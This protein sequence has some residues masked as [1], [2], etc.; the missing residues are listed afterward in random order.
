MTSSSTSSTTGERKAI[1]LKLTSSSAS[2][3]DD[4][5]PSLSSKGRRKSNGSDIRPKVEQEL[6]VISEEEA[7][8]DIQYINVIY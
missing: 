2:L 3:H 4:E 7:R 6:E 5:R 8:L 1:C